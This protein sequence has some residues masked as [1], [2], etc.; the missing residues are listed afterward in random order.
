MLG[1]CQCITSM[2]GVAFVGSRLH[3]LNSSRF[4]GVSSRSH[5]SRS[6]HVHHAK[7]RT[8]EIVPSHTR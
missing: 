5:I 3:V 8:G 6:Y 7:V 4:G 2:V 1:F